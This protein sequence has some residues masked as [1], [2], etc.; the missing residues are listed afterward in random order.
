[1]TATLIPYAIAWSVLASVVVL[2]A[3]YRRMVALHEDD[4]LHVRE[5]EMAMVTEQTQIAGKLH[6]IDK[7]GKILTTIGAVWAAVM[8]VLFVYWS[9]IENNAAAQ[10]VP[11]I[12]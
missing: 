3:V 4:T 1:M 7:W 11:V 9:W 12:R 6:A 5:S 8:I 10:S 2:L